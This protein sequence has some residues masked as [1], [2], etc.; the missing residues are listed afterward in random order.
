MKRI[1]RHKGIWILIA[2][3]SLS[4]IVTALSVSFGGW[5]NPLSDVARQLARPFA[6]LSRT[7]E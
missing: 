3:L 7:V 2:A 5:A 1:I 6:Y 4:L